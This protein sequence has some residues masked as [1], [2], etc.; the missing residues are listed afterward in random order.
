MFAYLQSGWIP[1]HRRRIKIT[2]RFKLGTKHCQKKSPPCKSSF[3][4]PTI[5][6]RLDQSP[7]ESPKF[8]TQAG[9]VDVLRQV[10]TAGRSRITE[11]RVHKPLSTVE[12]SLAKQIPHE[13]THDLAGPWRRVL[14]SWSMWPAQGPE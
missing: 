7:E 5:K 13:P 14:V 8:R 3:G 12:Q 11:Y 9:P 6:T 2:A 4:T 1:Y 10:Q